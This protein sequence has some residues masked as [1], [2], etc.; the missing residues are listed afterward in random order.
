M[1]QYL[2]LERLDAIRHRM[3]I[4]A[5]GVNFVK[6]ASQIAAI[7]QDAKHPNFFEQFSIDRPVTFELWKGLNYY[8]SSVCY[9]LAGVMAIKGYIDRR[10]DS[11]YL[12]DAL[13]VAVTTGTFDI[14]ERVQSLFQG[15]EYSWE[16]VAVTFVSACGAILLDRMIISRTLPTYE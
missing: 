10:G 14:I 4:G 1:E 3:F 12:N 15:K 5:A 8:T 16:D 7:V 6:Y 13:T 11:G 2:P 9:G